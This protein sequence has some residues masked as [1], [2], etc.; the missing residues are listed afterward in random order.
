MTKAKEFLSIMDEASGYDVRTMKSNILKVLKSHN[1]SKSFAISFYKEW[2]YMPFFIKNINPKSKYFEKSV[3]ID[4]DKGAK[5][6]TEKEIDAALLKSKELAPMF[7]EIAKSNIAR[8]K[9]HQKHL[10]ELEKERE[11]ARKEREQQAKKDKDTLKKHGDVKFSSDLVH[12]LNSAMADMRS[13]TA[14]LLRDNGEKP[15]EN[16]MASALAELALDAD[17][18]E[19]EELTELLDKYGYDLV[20][21]AVK[22]IALT[23][24]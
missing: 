3:R 15:T 11:V 19:S 10:K 2:G 5:A 12:K 1:I 18:V 7:K 4:L 6:W 22:K 24:L 8:E 16:N 20:Y 13:D 17:R 9:E 14:A 21:K 23:M